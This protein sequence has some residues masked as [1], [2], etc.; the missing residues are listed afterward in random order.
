[1]P[2]AQRT[3]SEDAE[4]R[5][6][7]QLSVAVLTEMDAWSASTRYRALQFVDRLR[8]LFKRVEVSTAGDT[9]A[10]PPGRLG[11]LR[12][13][14]GHAMRYLERGVRVREVISG[15]DRLM[16]Q[17]GLYPLGPGLIAETICRY[18]GRVVLDLDDAVFELRPSLAA[19]G[20][21]AR[22]MYGPQQ[23]LRLLERADAVVVSTPALAELLPAGAGEA[24]VLP[25]VPDPALYPLAEQLDRLPVV[26]GWAGTVGGLGYLDP[27]APVFERLARAGLTCLE[28]VC[29]QPWSG[30]AAFRPWRLAEE[31]SLFTRFGVGIM[32]LPDTP[33]TRA[34][35]G[36]KLLQYMAAG[37]PVVAS[38]VGM[39]AELVSRARAGYLAQSSEE[40]ESA[41]RELARDAELRRELG[42]RGRA[43]VEGF[44]DLDGH[45]RTLAGLLAGESA[46]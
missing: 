24:T 6:H 45:A 32:P 35:A 26:V 43:F 27:L 36:F 46:R 21:L 42:R 10:R 37:L 44:A 4:A 20:R 13:F 29:S 28:V 18:D 11:R 9:A 23:T 1:M 19:R 5:R 30:P 16:V 34:K 15:H 12:Y 38:P 25:T 22:W 8:P 14:S 7:A 41:L 31:T 40:W 3:R 2:D 39:N 17:R 33:Y